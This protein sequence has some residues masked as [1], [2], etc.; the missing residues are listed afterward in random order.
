MYPQ[1]NGLF[2][3]GK[4]QRICYNALMSI[5]CKLKTFL[6]ALLFVA[7]PLHFVLLQEGTPE[8]S[9]Y[10]LSWQAGENLE[11]EEQFYFHNSSSLALKYFHVQFLLMAAHPSPDLPTLKRPPKFFL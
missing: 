3:N 9:H 1:I 11:E 4:R 5:P 10:E 8:T 7:L 6:I 2:K